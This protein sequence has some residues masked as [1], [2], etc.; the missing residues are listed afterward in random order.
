LLP[1]AQ[2]A[3]MARI[4]IARDA[5]MARAAQEAARPGKTVVLVAGGGHV[6]RSI[7][8]PTHLSPSLVSKVAVAQA[9]K[10]QTAIKNDADTVLSTPALPARDA[11]AELREKWRPAG[12]Q[13]P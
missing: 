9:G 6:L 3:P 4:Q 10:G 5:S 11:C 2:I 7:G 13:R 8:V 12:G 1:E